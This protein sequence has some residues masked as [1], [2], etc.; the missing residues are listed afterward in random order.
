M[1]VELHRHLEGSV[2]YE[3][4][5]DLAA[6]CGMT[7]K[8]RRALAMSAGDPRTFRCFSTK[9]DPITALSPSRDWVERIAREAVEDAA[10]EGV[11]HL[12]LR[13]GPA[14]HA[15]RM[16]ADSVSVGGWIVDAARAEAR[17]RRISIAFVVTL[18]RHRPLKLNRPSLDAALALRPAVVGIDVAGPEWFSLDPLAP[19]LRRGRRAGLPLTIHAG[20]AGPGR[21]V[22]EAVQRYGAERIGHGVRCTRPLPGVHYEICLTSNRLTGTCRTLSRHPLR[23]MFDAG[24]SVSLNTDDPAIFGTTLDREYALARRHLGFSAA[25]LAEINRRAYAAAFR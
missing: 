8:P 4:Y 18:A 1:R 10:D 23:R 7:P 13:F 9:F 22:V 5:R 12:E 11:T 15:M 19:L 17:R 14:Y 24:L 25:E 2:R 21:N 16:T 3:T 20:E 6:D